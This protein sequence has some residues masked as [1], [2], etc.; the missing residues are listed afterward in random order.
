M[1][2]IA[3]FRTLITPE[4]D[5]HAHTAQ[6]AQVDHSHAG[7]GGG[8]IV[9]ADIPEDLGLKNLQV[10]FAGTYDGA[11][12]AGFVTE[13]A[14]VTEKLDLIDDAFMRVQPTVNVHATAVLVGFD[15]LSM[16]D[17]DTGVF[18]HR[19]EDVITMNHQVGIRAPGHPVEAATFQSE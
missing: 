5:E 6:H 8:A 14:T 18:V 4:S 11:M 10:S 16:T 15:P 2:G 12:P 17:K 9:E 7:G 3:T 19:G 1:I 13:S